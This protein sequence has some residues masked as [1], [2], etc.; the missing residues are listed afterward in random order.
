[1]A[2]SDRRLFDIAAQAHR[3]LPIAARFG[4]TI[5]FA[6]AVAGGSWQPCA[7]AQDRVVVL[8]SD[9]SRTVVREGTIVDWKGGEMRM[10]YNGQI[11]TIKN[12]RIVQI[13]TAWPPDYALAEEL[14]KQRKFAEARVALQNAIANESRG[15]AL[16]ILYAQQTRLCDVLGD[17][18][19]SAEM[20]MS[21]IQDDPDTRDFATIPLPWDLTPLETGLLDF[22]KKLQNSSVVPLQLLGA[23]WLVTS[24]ER[25]AA[26]KT[27]ELLS[28]DLDSRIAHLASAQ[29]WRTKAQE[30]DTVQLGR[31]E[32]QID[33][34]P[35]ELRA[36]PLLVLGQAQLRL[37]KTE[38]AILSW[39]QVPILH[40][41]N[42][43]AA[44][45]GLQLA[46]ATLQNN[47]ESAQARRLWQ[48]LND[49]FPGTRWG[50]LARGE[51][52]RSRTSP[53]KPQGP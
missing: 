48:E 19:H 37:G 7:I 4:A 39:L 21:L 17:R 9:N 53:F 30:V 28:R 24:P 38:D 11:N 47:G 2:V 35:R 44:A 50:D 45:S 22:G 20:F 29:L 5:L 34:M 26:I 36:G 32:R 23:S 41:E 25:A 40:E 10:E 46:A 31:W 6:A 8:L 51:L 49:R 43:V 42:L 3:W 16:R 15:W 1:M 14:L 18:R 33:R 12:D 27:L 52:E 13:Q